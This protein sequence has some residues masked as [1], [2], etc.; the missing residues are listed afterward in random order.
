MLDV[1]TNSKSKQAF[2]EAAG[3]YVI[4]ISIPALVL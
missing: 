3:S 1:L 4:M 2:G